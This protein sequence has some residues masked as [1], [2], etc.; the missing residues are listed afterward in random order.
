[1]GWK[2]RN[3]IRD[4][5]DYFIAS[6]AGIIV[7]DEPGREGEKFEIEERKGKLEIF[8]NIQRS[9]FLLRSG[10]LGGIENKSGIEAE[11]QI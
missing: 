6:G 4:I 3:T 1:M 7:T 5:Y 2:V 8:L 10:L 11:E 9:R